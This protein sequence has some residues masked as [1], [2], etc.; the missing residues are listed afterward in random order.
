MALEFGDLP[1]NRLLGYGIL[2]S[3][4]R[5]SGFFIFGFS[6]TISFVVCG[7]TRV[8]SL[9]ICFSCHVQG[10]LRLSMRQDGV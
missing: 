1:F 6:P 2:L 3:I 9:Y 4:L 8:L 7:N 5:G 10:R